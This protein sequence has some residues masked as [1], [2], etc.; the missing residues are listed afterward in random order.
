[1]TDN[2][3][4][5]IHVTKSIGE[6]LRAARTLTGLSAAHFA[7]KL[8]LHLQYL[9]ALEHDQLEQLPSR[10]FALG[11]LRKYARMLDL[12]ADAL[13]SQAMQDTAY[14]A[15]AIKTL[16]QPKAGNFVIR[17][18]KTAPKGALLIGAVL[19]LVL[20]LLALLWWDER[21]ETAVDVAQDDDTL[22]LNSTA[23][24]EQ[25]SSF[26]TQTSPSVAETD[27]AVHAPLWMT[28]EAV[29]GLSGANLAEIPDEFGTL[30]DAALDDASDDGVAVSHETGETPHDANESQPTMT[31]FEGVPSAGVF[32]RFSDNCWIN[33][34]EANG[35]QLQQ[36][37]M[38]ANQTAQFPLT[39]TL[40][41]VLGNVSAVEVFVNGQ[42]FDLSSR[43][44][45]N[46]ARFNLTPDA[47]E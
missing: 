37:I 33:V 2:Q 30:G 36:A 47:N 34:R 21:S 29:S 44:T 5:Q 4:E 31:V 39:T 24:A 10:V 45:N 13:L 38:Q 15:D 20:L 28:D 9:E 32:L 7:E 23:V 17:R 1:M 6:Q 26:S 41:L 12:D 27:A 42:P 25:Q 19:V 11:Y 8:R 14:P 43:T 3:D 46:V 35:R 18:N 40:Q 16:V 22:V